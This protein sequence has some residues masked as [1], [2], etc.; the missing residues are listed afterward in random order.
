MRIIGLLLLL[1]ILLSCSNSTKP[2]DNDP[3][4]IRL[5]LVDNSGNPLQGYRITIIQ[6]NFDGIENYLSLNKDHRSETFFRYY[7]EADYYVEFKIYDYFNQP[8]K[9]IIDTFQVR[10]SH[11]V[12]WNGK[13]D[14]G[15]SVRDGVYKAII[16]YYDDYNCKNVAFSDKC[17][18]YLLGECIID[19]SH[20][21]TD[22]NGEL[23]TENIIPFPI[24]YCNVPVK[25]ID[26]TGNEIRD[27]VFSDTMKVTIESPNQEYR[28]CIFRIING[29]NILNLNWATMTQVDEKANKH[30]AFPVFNTMENRIIKEKLPPPNQFY[31]NYPN[32]FN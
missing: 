2:D 7:M 24:L 14:A 9:T 22:A 31:G 17:Y 1:T 3:F 18:P 25:V 12:V 32:P 13:D 10:G 27:F 15:N 11:T 28:S 19:Q 4:S 30:T 23:F 29:K 21:T 26:E 5:K 16:I 8:V 20:Y 6:N